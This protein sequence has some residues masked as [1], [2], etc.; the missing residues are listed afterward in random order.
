MKL[1]IFDMDDVLY[2]Y[3]WRIRMASLTTLTGLPLAELR[4]RWWHGDGELAA[5]AGRFTD[6][7]DYL[8][9][10]TAALGVDVAESDWVTARGGAM[11]PW[12][13][14]IAAAR[15]ASELGRVTLLTNNGPLTQRHLPTL[16]PELVPVFG[17]H[18]LTS[19]HYGARK[20]EPEV[21]AA[22]LD[23]YGVRA[24]DAFFV[25]DLSENIAGAVSVG[26]TG[27]LFESSAGMRDAVEAFAAR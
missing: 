7:D 15:R 3:D 27:H 4:R 13:D 12:P 17:E 19:S 5:E 18:L 8:A 10:F 16:A 23:R 25:D 9:A 6:G 21:F 14:S 22:V 26:I 20:P 2:D 24:D 11:T 1:F